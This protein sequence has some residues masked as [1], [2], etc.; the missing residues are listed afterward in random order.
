MKEN[1]LA[2]LFQKLCLKEKEVDMSQITK[3]TLSGVMNL[4]ALTP[5]SRCSISCPTSL[6]EKESR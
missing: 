6:K 3:L 4:A 2:W 5:V 1:Q